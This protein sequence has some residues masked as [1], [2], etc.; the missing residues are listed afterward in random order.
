MNQ[1]DMNQQSVEVVDVANSPVLNLNEV[2]EVALYENKTNKRPAIMLL[3]AGVFSIV[4]GIVYPIIMD[5]L[6]EEPVVTDSSS[7]STSTTDVSSSVLSCSYSNKNDADGTNSKESIKFNF[8]SDD[9]L[10]NYSKSLYMVPIDGNQNGL[11]TV[12]SI[13]DNLIL[14]Q[15]NNIDGYL[16]TSSLTDGVLQSSLSVNLELLDYSLLTDNYFT[17][18]YT[19]VSFNKNNT[20]EQV[21][22]LVTDSGYTCE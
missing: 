9:T 6:E 17:N 3:I 4:M 13:Y 12:Q 22:K 21:K 2:E 5:K 8:T 20:Y 19:K 1:T 7:S 11:V 10:T 16:L 14:L 18:N 15:S